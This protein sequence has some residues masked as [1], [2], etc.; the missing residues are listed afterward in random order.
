MS[1]WIAVAIALVVAI[2]GLLIA[3]VKFTHWLDAKFSEVERKA[4]PNGLDSLDV[5]DTAARTEI[6]VDEL[7]GLFLEHLVNHPGRT[8]RPPAP[9]QPTREAVAATQR[10]QNGDTMSPPA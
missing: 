5:G 2:A 10:A 4:T 9:S 6:K 8:R 7:R 3:A 1:G